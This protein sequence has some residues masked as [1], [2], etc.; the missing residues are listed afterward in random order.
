MEDYIVRATAGE[1]TVRAVAAVTTNMVRKAK[2]IHK[3]SPLASAALGRVLTGI[4]IMSTTLKN[5]SD[6]ITIQIKG[7]GPIGGIVAVSD[8]HANVRGYVYNPMV[9][10]PLNDKGKFDVGRAVGKGYLNVIKDMGLRE[11]YIGYVDL[12]SGEIAEDIAYYYAFSEQVPTVFSCGVLVDT[13]TSILEAGGYMIQLLPGASEEMV[14][15]LENK[16][17]GIKPITTLLREGNTPEDILDLVLGDLGLNIIGKNETRYKCYCSRERM[18][19]NLLSLGRKELEDMMAQQHGARLE[20]HF[21][22]ETYYFSE[23]EI[24]S[25]LKDSLA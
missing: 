2:D 22:N 17:A 4:A 18:E 6:T 5:E 3:L 1:G 12:V 19:K 8:A 7:D 21:C 15:L 25:L 23:E 9:N 24:R 13:D 16:V 10:L 11:P 20:C 14:G